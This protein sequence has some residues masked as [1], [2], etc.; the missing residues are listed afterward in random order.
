[1]QGDPAPTVATC[2]ETNVAAGNT[3]SH[4]VTYGADGVRRVPLTVADAKCGEAIAATGTPTVNSSQSSATAAASRTAG[5]WV[6]YVA[7]AVAGAV[8]GL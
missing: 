1:M 8:V 3:F 5:T 7:G 6:K 4:V 2:S